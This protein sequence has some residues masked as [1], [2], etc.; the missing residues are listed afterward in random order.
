MSYAASEW[1]NANTLLTNVTSHNSKYKECWQAIRRAIQLVP[2][3]IR[4]DTTELISVLGTRPQV[5]TTTRRSAAFTFRQARWLPFQ[6]QSTTVLCPAP[7]YAA[8]CQTVWPTSRSRYATAPRP[9]VESAF[10][11]LQ[12]QRD[13]HFATTTRYNPSKLAAYNK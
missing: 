1:T 3:S 9:E 5:T 10:I 11:W 8:S 7:Y 12:F 6:P 4:V 13:T 2:Y